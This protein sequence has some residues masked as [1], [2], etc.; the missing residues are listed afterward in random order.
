VSDLEQEIAV[1]APRSG[2]EEPAEAESVAFLRRSLTDLE[3]EWA[4]GDLDPADHA[5]LRDEYTTRLAWALRGERDG[6]GAPPEARGS[7]PTAGRP[8]WVWLLWGLFVAGL[9]L[10]AGVL[11]AR[12]SG[13]R[14]SGQALTG[15]IRQ[16]AAGR[17]DQCHELSQGTDV[18]GAVKC[19]DAVLKDQPSSVEALTYRAWT[20][21]RTGA[22]ALLQA[23]SDNLDQAV[24]LDPSYAD[25]RVF[26]AVVRRDLGRVDEARADLAAFDALNPPQL[27]RSLVDRMGL[28]DSLR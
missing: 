5:Q 24:S 25:A 16:G 6:E 22:P 11:V 17:L 10:G 2:E 19:Y 1:R 14:T 13:S 26:R 3:Q 23:A 12:S 20:L 28:R 8:R 9:A 7:T 21:I 27:M 15:E 4:A 18:V